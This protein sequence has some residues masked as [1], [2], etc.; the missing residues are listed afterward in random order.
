VKIDLSGKKKFYLRSV[1]LPALI[2]RLAIINITSSPFPTD[3]QDIL[4]S[5]IRVDSR[6]HQPCLN[7]SKI[8]CSQPNLNPPSLTLIIPPMSTRLQK[9]YPYPSITFPTGVHIVS[10]EAD[11]ILLTTEVYIRKCNY[12]CEFCFHTSKNLYIL[13]LSEA[14]RGLRLMAQAGMKKLNISGGEPFLKPEFLGEIFKFC[15]E[16]LHL[17]SCSVV[18]NASKVTEKWLDSYGRYLDIMAISCD[19]FDVDTCLQLGRAEKGQGS[20]IGRVFKVA[21]WCRDRGIQVKINTVV[22]RQ[23]FPCFVN[24]LRARLTC[25]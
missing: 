12:S 14:Q 3:S 18:S 24:D 2:I 19:S 1:A 4:H 21:D 25:T 23:V 7:G 17:E 5:P 16:E 13:P 11:H 22:T 15:K 8:N 20:H 10:V 6:V 9:W